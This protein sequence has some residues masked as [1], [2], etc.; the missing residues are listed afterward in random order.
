M[1]QSV[2]MPPPLWLHYPR[3]PKVNKLVRGQNA[4]EGSMVCEEYSIAKCL[5]IIANVK[6]QVVCNLIKQCNNLLHMNSH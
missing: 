6:Y 1:R 2:R 3:N 4:T 5:M